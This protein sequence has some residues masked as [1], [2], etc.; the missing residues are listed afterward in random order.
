MKRAPLLLALA[1]ATPLGAQ[2]APWSPLAPTADVPHTL[3]AAP[4]PPELVLVPHRPLGLFGTAGNPA[5]AVFDLETTFS[6]Y[7]VALDHEQGTYRRPLD[8]RTTT[9]PGVAVSAESRVTE[10]FAAAGGV[11][12]DARAAD[13]SSYAHE[14]LPYGSSPLAEADTSTSAVHRPAARLDGALAW[15]AGGWGFGGAVS[16][17]AV[18]NRTLETRLPRFGHAS[19]P[20]AALGVARVLGPVTLGLRARYVYGYEHFHIIAHG[21]NGTAYD[22]QGLSDP[23]VRTISSASDYFRRYLRDG[24]GV[25]GSAAGRALGIAWV[26]DVERVNQREEQ[27]STEFSA[28]P[29]YDRWRAVGWRYDAAVRRALPWSWGELTGRLSSVSFDGAAVLAAV[30]GIFYESHESLLDLAGEWR[31]SPAD[32]TWRLGATISTRHH[33]LDQQDFLS[34]RTASLDAWE[35]AFTLSVAHRMHSGLWWEAGTGLA[36]HYAASSFPDPDSTSLPYQRYVAPALSLEATL[37]A[38]RSY[39]IA[40]LGPLQQGASWWATVEYVDSH[41]GVRSVA[42][43]RGPILSARRGAVTL[44]TGIAVGL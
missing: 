5:A 6:S 33:V 31:W 7:R 19:F 4:L 10:R 9:A 1:A 34:L 12:V 15:R 43:P 39:R 30:R 8:L 44:A 18:D 35:P 21:A 11:A 25:Q 3:F 27:T 23:Q 32:S 20:A 36:E 13:P 29:P 26:A 24:T 2:Q 17:E 22:I 38:A 37:A 14:L 28:H 40:L 16:Y 41:P 42:L